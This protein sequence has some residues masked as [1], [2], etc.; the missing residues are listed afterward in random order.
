MNELQKVTAEMLSIEKA[1]MAY[2]EATNF[3]KNPN[4][5]EAEIE[6]SLVRWDELKAKRNQLKAVI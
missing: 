3:G 4:G 6:Q 1:N 5:K 2:N